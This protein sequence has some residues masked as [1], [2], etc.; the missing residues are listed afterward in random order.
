MSNKPSSLKQLKDKLNYSASPQHLMPTA[1]KPDPKKHEA[2][3]D[4]KRQGDNDNVGT[5][6]P[7][8]TKA[9]KG[10][11]PSPSREEAEAAQKSKLQR[12]QQ[13]AAARQQVK[14]AV[15]YSRVGEEILIRKEITPDKEVLTKYDFEN[16]K[17]QF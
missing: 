1:N 9:P 8:T 5:G 3:K 11:Q 15:E 14:P 7:V 17:P 6:R 4:F 12:A 10:S 16:L 2:P 13:A